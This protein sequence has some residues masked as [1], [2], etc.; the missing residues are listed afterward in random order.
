MT[1]SQLNKYIEFHGYAE[2]RHMLRQMLAAK[3]DC[4]VDGRIASLTKEQL[5]AE[6]ADDA[7]KYVVVWHGVNASGDVS[8]GAFGNYATEKDAD[9]GLMS[10]VF[11]AID[12]ANNNDDEIAVDFG[13]KPVVIVRYCGSVTSYKVEEIHHA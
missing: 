8:M 3:L 5:V 13:A 4:E 7:T 11:E 10:S 9:K 1:A 2:C 12:V 6:L